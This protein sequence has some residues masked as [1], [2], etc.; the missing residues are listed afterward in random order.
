MEKGRDR[1][2]ACESYLRATLLTHFSGVNFML[3][4]KPKFSKASLKRNLL[5]RGR[6]IVAQPTALASIWRVPS[7]SI[8]GLLYTVNV[9]D[10]RGILETGCNCKS[11][12]V[13]RGCWHQLSVMS[14]IDRDNRHLI[15]LLELQSQEAERVA[16]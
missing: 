2:T 4:R 1:D 8:A 15:A 3:R 11:G 9:E 14:E 13:K 7:G 5:M 12:Q 6:G 10:V 16:A